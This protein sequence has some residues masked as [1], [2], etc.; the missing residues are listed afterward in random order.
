MPASLSYKDVIKLLKSEGNFVVYENRGK[1]GHRMICLENAKGEKL[2][3]CPIP[4]HGSKPISRGVLKVIRRKFGLPDDFFES[5]N[6]KF[7]G[8][9][10]VQNDQGVQ[11]DEGFKRNKKRK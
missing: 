9:H 7:K 5:K 10:R 11:D 6:R 1:G 2:A 3:V 4:Y 8:S